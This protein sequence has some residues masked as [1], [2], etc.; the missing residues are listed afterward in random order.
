MDKWSEADIDR[1]FER[2]QHD[3]K[4]LDIKSKD[5]LYNK[6]TAEGKN[7]HW[8]REMNTFFY[9]IAHPPTK[10]KEEEERRKQEEKNREES[11][12]SIKTTKPIHKTGIM[13]KR[14]SSDDVN[15]ASK[16]HKE[17]LTYKQIA[18]HMDRTPSSVSNKMSRTKKGVYKQ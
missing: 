8:T 2:L 11:P 13:R 3:V 1:V 12:Y 18:S 10:E 7:K 9:N 6:V 15:T 4:I 17:G 16:L 14:W 5:E